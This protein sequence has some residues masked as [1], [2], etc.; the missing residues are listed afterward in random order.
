MGG[1]RRFLFSECDGGSGGLPK[2]V[3]ILPKI[4]DKCCEFVVVLIS[5]YRYVN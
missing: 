1:S 2:K 5:D 4:G 3:V